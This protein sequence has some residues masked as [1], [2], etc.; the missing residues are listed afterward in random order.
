[1][2]NACI[3]KQYTNKKY[4][5]FIYKKRKKTKNIHLKYSIYA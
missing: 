4:T 2:Q 3:K 5:F 1:M